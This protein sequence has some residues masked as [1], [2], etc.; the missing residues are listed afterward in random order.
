MRIVVDASVAVKWLVPESDSIIAMQ[1]LDR[2]HELHAPRLLVSETTNALWRIALSGVLDRYKAQRLADEVAGMP[3]KWTGDEAI[4]TEALRFALELGQ[5]AYDCMYLALA[6]RIGGKV[7]TADK[8]F[9]SAVDS[10]EY[11]SAVV[12]LWEFFGNLD[13][14][15]VHLRT[16]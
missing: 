8:R 5:P 1:L 10:T 6:V 9:V 13:G 3:L 14:G 12:P 16:P 4:C 15:L 11:K 7:V 2:S